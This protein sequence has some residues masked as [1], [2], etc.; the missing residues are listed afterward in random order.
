MLTK[1]LAELKLY[2]KVTGLFLGHKAVTQQRTRLTAL[3][4]SWTVCKAIELSMPDAPY[5]ASFVSHMS[6]WFDVMNSRIP[7]GK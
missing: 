3:L 1:D 6:A 7:A 4:Q 2:F 5:F